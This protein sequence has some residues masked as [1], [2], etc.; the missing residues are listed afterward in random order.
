MKNKALMM[1]A[2][3]IFAVMLAFSATGCFSVA[4]R[5]TRGDAKL[6]PIDPAD[7]VPRDAEAE[8]Y[9]RLGSSDK[10]IAVKQTISVRAN[11]LTET[12]VLEALASVPKEHEGLLVPAVADM[13]DIVDVQ[14]DGD[15]LYVTLSEKFTDKTE[16]QRRID[17]LER[18]RDD[19]SSDEYR[20]ILQAIRD[21]HYSSVRLSIYAMI[22]SL[23]SATEADRVQL[24]VDDGTGRGVRVSR[25]EFGLEPQSSGTNSDILEPLKRFES[26]TAGMGDIA[27]YF[28]N[29]LVSKDYDT[30]YA[31]L[32]PVSGRGEKKPSADEFK[33]IMNALCTVDDYEILGYLESKKGGFTADTRL[34]V[35]YADGRPRILYNVKLTAYEISGVCKFD[36]DALYKTLNDRR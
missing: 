27:S 3:F 25:R 19:I 32:S 17:E 12:A 21:E 5:E 22:N 9:Y 2:L 8:L 36:F 28:L 23:L 10:L 1:A 14:L 26:V 35:S 18:S 31:M 29:C 15:I 33:T 4:L 24:L 16:M 7:G 20:S 13:E 34:S 11:E 6:P 30:A